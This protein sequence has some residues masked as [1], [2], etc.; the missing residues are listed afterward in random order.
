VTLRDALI[1]AALLLV[2][3]AAL[4]WLLLSRWPG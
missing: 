1:Y 2:E 4:L 3:L